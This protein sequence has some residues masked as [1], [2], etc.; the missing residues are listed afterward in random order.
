MEISDRRAVPG[1]AEADFSTLV[2]AE[3]PGLYRYAVSIVGDRAEAEDLIGDT[4]LRALERREQ[5]RAEAS[6]RTWLHRIL[7]HL[8]IDRGRR[9]GREV[10]VEEVESSWRD[11]DYSVDPAVVVERAQSAEALREALVHLPSAHRSVL[12]LHD[13]EG[14]PVSEVAEVLGI[15][16][17]AAKQR[18]RRGRMMLVS[19]LARGE[20]RRM[21]NQGVPLS[22]W[23][24]RKSVSAYL[25][26]ELA[27]GE[28]TALETHLGRC[29]T[30]PPLYQALVGAT[31]SL[32][33][34][35]DPDSVVPAEVAGRVRARTGLR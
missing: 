14:W 34:L 32:G 18:L 29:A 28:R 31:A 27:S 33:A 15:S 17:P 16:L 9:A 1:E 26:G 19:S 2:A 6:L 5:Y 10:S 3:L 21:A 12:V 25:D 13:A 22:C 11:A 23:E 35:H 24:A 30:C 20:E 7:Y 8:A 4:V